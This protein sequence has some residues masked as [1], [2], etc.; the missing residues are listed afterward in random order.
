MSSTIAFIFVVVGASA[1]QSDF[2]TSV[3]INVLQNKGQ[4]K[5]NADQSKTISFPHPVCKKQIKSLL[6]G[7]KDTYKERI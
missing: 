3:E 5:K 6:L 2:V 1:L 4:I 7:I